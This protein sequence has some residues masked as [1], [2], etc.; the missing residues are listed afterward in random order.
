L[1]RYDAWSNNLVLE[2]VRAL[3]HPIDEGLGICWG[4][5]FRQRK[6]GWQG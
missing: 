4:I 2:A 5:Y 3:P 1:V 6:F